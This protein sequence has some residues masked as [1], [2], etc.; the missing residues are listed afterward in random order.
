MSAR[1]LS[2]MRRTWAGLAAYPGKASFYIGTV[3]ADGPEEA[4]RELA[5]LWARLSP[6]PAP[7]ITEVIP[8]RLVFVAED[9]A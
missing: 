5:A 4:R 8:G 7:D 9:D 2:G 1:H 3:W 6:Y